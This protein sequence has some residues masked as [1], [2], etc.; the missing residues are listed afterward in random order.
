MSLP[1]GEYKETPE[2]YCTCKKCGSRGKVLSRP[3]WYRHN[4]GGKGERITKYTPERIDAILSLPPLPA[5]RRR[6]R[7][8][9]EAEAT[10]RAHISKRVAGG[11]G[12]VSA[13][14]DHSI[15]ASIGRYSQKYVSRALGW[16]R[17]LLMDMVRP[18]E[19]PSPPLLLPRSSIHQCYLLVPQTTRTMVLSRSSYLLSLQQTTQLD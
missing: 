16:M 18:R 17:K 4:P 11:S 9:E 12:S 14:L 13:I 8:L 10:Y 5:S 3:T 6:K 15:C 2:F 1:P 19:H 7:R